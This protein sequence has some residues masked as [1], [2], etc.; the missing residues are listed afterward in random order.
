MR[1][2]GIK[3]DSC[4]KI[5]DKENMSTAEMRAQS[6]YNT[7]HLSN[8]DDEVK[9]HLVILLMKVPESKEKKSFTSMVKSLSGAWK[10]NGLTAEEEIK[11]IYSARTS[12]ETRKLVDL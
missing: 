9:R 8:I 12:G 7:M 5:K 1:S 11:Q 4:R 3:E 6:I 10:D 2:S